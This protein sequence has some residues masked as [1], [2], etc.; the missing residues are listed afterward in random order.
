MTTGAP[1]KRFSPHPGLGWFRRENLSEPMGKIRGAIGLVVT[2]KTKK[3]NERT[4]THTLYYHS[5][6]THLTQ[7][8]K[9]SHP[10]STPSEQI[11]E[12]M[13]LGAKGCRLKAIP[14]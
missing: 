12:K 2:K 11:T 10:F 1:R 5:F 6:L 3:E 9:N 13:V 8:L 4:K 7:R 14:K